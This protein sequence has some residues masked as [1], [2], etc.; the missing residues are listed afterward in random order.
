[1]YSVH[2][3]QLTND[4]HK[5]LFIKAYDDKIKNSRLPFSQINRSINPQFASNQPIYYPVLLPCQSIQGGECNCALVLPLSWVAASVV[6]G[7]LCLKEMWVVLAMEGFRDP[8]T[9]D[10]IYSAE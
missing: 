10:E 5:F 9:A 6:T 7:L 8:R 1:M 4:E 2:I 3:S